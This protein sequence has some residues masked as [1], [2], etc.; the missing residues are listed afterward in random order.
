ML[1]AVGFS[2]PLWA[3]EQQS[4][5]TGYSQLHLI[6]LGGRPSWSDNW[7]RGSWGGQSAMSWEGRFVCLARALQVSLLFLIGCVKECRFWKGLKETYGGLRL[8]C[9]DIQ[10]VWSA[11]LVNQ[12]KWTKQ[13][14]KA[15]P[16]LPIP[17]DEGTEVRKQLLVC[18]RE[19][20]RTEDSKGFCV[21]EKPHTI[22]IVEV[23]MRTNLSSGC[24]LVLKAFCIS[25]IKTH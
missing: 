8:S 6:Q 4:A 5:Q 14:R 16:F 24:S 23:L 19:M 10:W 22:C 15:K 18:E 17:A 11:C 2:V 25:Y 13:N 9:E 3:G 1:Q 21:Y 20:D 7:G 12:R